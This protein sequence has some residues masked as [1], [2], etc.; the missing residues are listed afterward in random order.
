MRTGK[1]RFLIL[2]IGLAFFPQAVSASP[3]NEVFKDAEEAYLAGDFELGTKKIEELIVS[4]PGDFDLAARALH[5]LCL[6]EYAQL[7][8]RDWP[9][10]GFPKSLFR[11]SGKDHS[12]MWER[13]SEYLEEAFLGFGPTWRDNDSLNLSP[14]GNPVEAAANL[15]DMLRA[16]DTLALGGIA[17]APIPEQGIGAAIN[18]RLRRAAAPR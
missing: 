2:S 16:L 14:S 15:F 13:L 17:V 1:F 4:N 18:D 3:G 5:R 8:S 10:G 11:I 9:S 7:V 12:R 6:S